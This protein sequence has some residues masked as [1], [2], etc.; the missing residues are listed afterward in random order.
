MSAAGAALAAAPADR[1]ARKW[2]IAAG[3]TL[4]AVLELI[5][6]SII[7]VALSQMSANL[8]TTLDEIA[9]VSTAYIIAAVIVLPM[10]G[11]LSALIGRRRYYVGSI[12]LFT[13][14]SFLCGQSSSLGEI[15]LWRVVQGIGGGALI[16]TSQ[17]ILV[18]SFPPEEQT[19]AAAIFGVGMMVG[20]AIGPTLG[21]IIVDNYDWPWIF[22]INVPVGIT[23]AIV[24]W[25]YTGNPAHQERPTRFDLVGILLV[26]VG[27]GSLQFV[28]ERGEHYDWFDSNL[29]RGFVAIA[30]VAIPAFVWWELRVPQPILNLRVLRNRSLAAGSVFAAAL[31]VGLYGS[32]FALPLYLQQVLGFD[33]TQAGWALFPGAAGSAV[34][35]LLIARASNRITDLRWVIAFGAVLLVS[36]MWLHGRFTTD[37]GSADLFWPVVLRGMGTGF[38]FVPLATSSTAS[39]VGR[40]LA[41]GSA[42]FNLTRQLG[43]SIGIAVLATQ[44]TRAQDA[45]RAVLVEHVTSLDLT[46]S[47]RLAAI[48]HGLVAR[49]IA[50]EA[51]PARALELLDLTIQRQAAMLAYVDIFHT[52]ALVVL[53]SV[54]L[55][56]LL[57]KPARGQLHMGE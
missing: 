43:G 24:T 10:T 18:E 32:V 17:A 4:A 23:A 6:T 48:T 3:V 51:A 35:L 36:G 33:A 11:W 22:Y 15:V 27:A 41:E 46:T 31:G 19:L 44:L 53:C 38:M 54:P 21:G 47:D 55:I 9:W 5:D 49:G 37:S 8:G 1:Y 7:N 34:A 52:V 30:A 50:P 16:A 25:L 56:L 40:D 20:P 2:V 29:I 42:I 39:L 28:L 14:A 26:I 12:L 57:Q 13:T 45:H